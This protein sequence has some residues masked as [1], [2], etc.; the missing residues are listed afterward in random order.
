MNSYQAKKKKKDNQLRKKNTN[1]LSLVLSVVS[2]AHRVMPAEALLP[3][4]QTAVPGVNL[5]GGP[6]CLG[7]RGRVHRR[8]TGHLNARWQRAL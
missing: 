5:L 6:F 3:A 4:F 1:L 7:E 8:C 2:L